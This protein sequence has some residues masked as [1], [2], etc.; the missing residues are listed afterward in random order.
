MSTLI[1]TQ[2]QIRA[3]LPM[4]Q[5]VD[6]VAEALASLASGEGSNPLRRGMRLADGKSL[7]GMMPGFLGSERAP[8]PIGLKV[9][10]VFPDNGKQSLPSIFGQYML[11]GALGMQTIGYLWI[12]QVIKI[13]V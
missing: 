2:P 1:L 12:K 7:L 3:L 10:T 5:C 4:R 8:G 13:E 11:M 6:L 9:V